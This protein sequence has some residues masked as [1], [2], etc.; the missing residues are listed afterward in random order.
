[1]RGART[2][3]WRVQGQLNSYLY[4]YTYTNIRTYTYTHTRSVNTECLEYLIAGPSRMRLY[5]K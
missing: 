4:F 2:P 3:T 1:M 5:L